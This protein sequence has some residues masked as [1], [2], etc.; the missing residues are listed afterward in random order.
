MVIVV[1]VMMVSAFSFDNTY[2]HNRSLAYISL[3]SSSPILKYQLQPNSYSPCERQLIDSSYS[4]H[5]RV[6]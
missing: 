2:L 6:T 1:V 4:L 5:M 3:N